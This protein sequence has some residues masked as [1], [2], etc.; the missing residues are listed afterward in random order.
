MKILFVRPPVPQKTLGLK[1]I[2]I[3]EPLG[4]EYAAAGIG[5]EHEVQIF[6]ALVERGLKKR[7]KAFKPDVVASNCYITGVNEVIKVS[8]LAKS[9]NP[10]CFTIAGGVHATKCPAD[11]A[12]TAVDCVVMGD[13]TTIMPEIIKALETGQPIEELPG[14]AIPTGPKQVYKTSGIPPIPDAN[15]LPFPRRDLVAHLKHKYYYIFHDPLATMKTTW[16]CWYK[17]NF[18]FTWTITEGRVFSRSPESIVAELEQIEA[19][20]VYIVDDIFLIK[21][22]RMKRMKE[23]LIEKGIKKKF[24]VYGRADFIAQN[25][26]IIKE[27]AEIGLSAVLIGLEAS[28]DSELDS[29]NKECSVD[30]N[31]KAIEVLTRNGV[32]TYGSLIPDPSYTKQ[33]WE[34]LF[35][36]IEETGLY[37]LN[38]SPLTPLPGTSVYEKYKDQITVPREAHGLWDLSHVLLPTK[39]SLKEFYRNLLWL[40]AKACMD[41]KRAKTL[42]MRKRPKWWTKKFVRLYWGV[43][44][45]Y[46][47]LRYAH[48]DHTPRSIRKAMYKG[49]EVPGLSYRKIKVPATPSPQ[50]VNV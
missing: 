29:M 6:D 3:C 40:Y 44:R 38:V 24:L 10:N 22:S 26:P 36:F 19:E 4:L 7:L 43:F 15:A 5:P 31:R 17:C 47:R 30:Y 18:C 27:W 49:P 1:N 50:G 45:S 41:P 37:Y 21:P 46:W 39:V 12:D 11:F 34:R 16:G 13:G 48:L 35:A 20:D 8:R 33:E 9:L 32:D 42:S 25:E 28:T 2:M 14:L 23:L